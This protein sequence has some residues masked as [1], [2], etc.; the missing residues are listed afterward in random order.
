MNDGNYNQWSYQTP[1]IENEVTVKDWLLTML[2]LCVP[3]VNIVMIFVWAFGGGSKPSKS[4]F[5]KAM[6]VWVVI[7]IVISLALGVTMGLAL[8]NGFGSNYLHV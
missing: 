1:G 2:I 8:F 7:G 3:I 4:N 6:L 5:F